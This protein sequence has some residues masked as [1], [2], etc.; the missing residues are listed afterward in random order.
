MANKKQYVSNNPD[1]LAEW[2][3]QKNSEIGLYPDSVTI[4]SK[5]RAW[6][7]CCA[8]GHQWKAIIGSRN[9][10]NGCPKCGIIM[11]SNNRKIKSIKNGTNSLA[12]INPKLALEW[13]YE[14]NSTL[15]PQDYAPNS[16]TKVWWKCHRCGYSWQAFISNR[17][18]GNGCPACSNKVVWQG[19]N[20]LETVFPELALEWCFDRNEKLPNEYVAGG[21]TKVWWKCLSCGHEWKATIAARVRGSGCPKC[22]FSLHTSLPEQCIFYFISLD[23]PNAVNS[24]QATWLGGREIDIYIPEINVG[25]EYDGGGWHQDINKDKQKTQLLKEH[26]INLIRIREENCPA[27]DDGSIVIVTKPCKSNM[28]YLQ[29]TMKIL[30]YH[31]S[32]F[33]KYSL[34]FT[35]DVSEV[36]LKILKNFRQKQVENSVSVV[37]PELLE[38]W[39]YDL[40]QGLSP[41][42]IS[43]NSNI[44]VY[45]KCKKCGFS[46]QATVDHRRQGYG[47]AR[48]AGQVVWQGHNDFATM[49]PEKLKIWNYQKNSFLPTEITVK[50]HKKI[51]W[52]CNNCGGEWQ[53]YVYN[54]SS[55]H[56]CPFCS[57]R[58]L[59]K[60]YNDLATRYPNIANEWDY[61]K[62]NGL[63]P[64]EIVFGSS[65]NVWWKCNVCNHEWQAVVY[66]R[67]QGKGCPRCAREKIRI[68][69]S[70]A[71]NQYSLENAFIARYESATEARQKTGA[72]CI[73]ECCKNKRKTSGGFIWRYADE[74]E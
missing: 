5:K 10:G 49:C 42:L 50:A 57:G 36:Y 65:K 60:G 74:D 47:C 53:A 55:G 63:S 59:K 68:A 14:K 19:H 67:V 52:K 39:D 8:C 13:D 12:V 37:S 46:W 21:H 3:H 2:D 69:R 24:Y 45:W 29:E 28:N 73:T 48:C 25:I 9:R 26:G 6:W 66:S 64:N 1:L 38:E 56:G 72:K 51:W 30:Y 23:F 15:G 70:R 32:E 71:V 40:N 16:H 31:L 7:K 11:N 4:G 22:T 20:D 44:K 35:G 17:N 18:Y 27:I 33:V 41:S 54:V 34:V 61:L 43:A 58:A 62:N